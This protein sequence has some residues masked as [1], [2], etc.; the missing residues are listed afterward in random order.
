MAPVTPSSG[1][2]SGSKKTPA[3]TPAKTP[4]R[5]S[6]KKSGKKSEVKKAR[7]VLSIQR[8]V[9]LVRRMEKG[10]S[11][12]MLMEEF[13]V[14]SSTLYDLKKQK[15]KLLSFVGS[16]ECPTKKIE[17]RKTLK[18]SSMPELD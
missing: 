14:S 8:K 1:S 2:S 16:T 7:F 17:K 6:V 9:E 3:K 15:D 5:G 10:E 4:D 11:R 18:G 12:A 13:G